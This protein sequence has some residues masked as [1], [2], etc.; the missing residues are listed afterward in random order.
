MLL[1]F[2]SEMLAILLKSV[3]PTSN[4]AFVQ[5]WLAIPR[6]VT[7]IVCAQ[8]TEMWF[9]KRSSG[10]TIIRNQSN[11]AIKVMIMNGGVQIHE[12]KAVIMFVI[13]L[14]R[15]SCLNTEIQSWKHLC[16]HT[17]GYIVLQKKKHRWFWKSDCTTTRWPYQANCSRVLHNPEKPPC[18][19]I[20]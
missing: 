9:C 16:L 7:F 19:L 4:I 20:L 13:L 6:A 1:Y 17:S 2:H 18:Q 12:A 3:N 15:A 14:R 10:L 11:T 8:G 5:I